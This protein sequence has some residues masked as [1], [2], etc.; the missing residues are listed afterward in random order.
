M[1]QTVKDLKTA[2][3]SWSEIGE[4]VEHRF[5]VKL[6]KDQLKVLAS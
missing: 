5:G 1:V 3:R 6:D 4:Q 2:G